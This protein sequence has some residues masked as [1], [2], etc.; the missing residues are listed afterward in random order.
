MCTHTCAPAHAHTALV[1]ILLDNVCFEIAP[2][3]LVAHFLW[4]SRSLE[5]LGMSRYN[6]SR[7]QGDI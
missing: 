1:R 2:K 7:D 4:Q 3:S 5:V 6:L